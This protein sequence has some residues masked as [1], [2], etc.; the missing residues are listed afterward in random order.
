MEI[1]NISKSYT[2]FSIAK[3]ILKR[4]DW[5]KY[6]TIPEWHGRIIDENILTGDAGKEFNDVV[7]KYVNNYIF[8]KKMPP[9]EIATAIV[10]IADDYLNEREVVL[11][12]GDYIA[13]QS[14]VRK[15]NQ[16]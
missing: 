12:A 7:N 3:E 16:A 10:N 2:A 14:F 8:K 4:K 15:V 6:K 11:K 13:L 1:I 5:V 9:A